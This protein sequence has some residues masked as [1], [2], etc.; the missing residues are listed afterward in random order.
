VITSQLVISLI[1]V[2]VCNTRGNSLKL[3][4]CHIVS[5]RDC[6]FL[7]IALLMCGICFP[8]MLLRLQLWLALSTDLPNL[9]LRCSA[10]I[11][12]TSYLYFRAPVSAVLYTDFV[13]CWHIRCT[14][15]LLCHILLFVSQ[16]YMI[17]SYLK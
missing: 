15:I 2:T 13:S 16:T 3:T 12:L 11:N 4:K 8:I 1:S 14:V 6:H 9:I 10:V 17:W 7:I 5:K